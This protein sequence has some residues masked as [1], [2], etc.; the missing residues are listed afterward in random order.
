[1]S[2]QL[3][4]KFKKILKKA[5]FTHADLEYHQELV[6]EA[7]QQFSETIS[8]IIENLS[9]EDKTRIRS[10]NIE[11][12]KKFEKELD[13][14]RKAPT[15]QDDLT[16]DAEEE[17]TNSITEPDTDDEEVLEK[18]HKK[19]E[20]KKV[21]H[22]IAELTHPDKVGVSGFS[23]IE[24]LRLE[25]IFKRARQAYE[26]ENWYILYTIAVDL[27]IELPIPTQENIKW[28]EDDIVNTLTKI[29]EIAGSLVWVWYTGDD[30]AKFH[31]LKCYFQ[32]NYGLDLIETND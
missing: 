26:D 21:F 15:H 31:A 20:L 8:I 17:D 25:K 28:T 5:D 14:R 24:C 12:Q 18:N 4:L 2:K 11:R 9:E 7:K 29:S 32:Q 13:A 6:P 1:M 22:R 16:E 23:D 27:A 10:A 3:K 19:S 30:A